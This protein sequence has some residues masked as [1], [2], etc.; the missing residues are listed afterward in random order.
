MQV[1]TG[2][3]VY[4]PGAMQKALEQL[5]D[6]KIDGNDLGLTQYKIPGTV[7][8][9]SPYGRA[10]LPNTFYYMLQGIRRVD[11]PESIGI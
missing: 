7:T 4:A 1:A 3:S 9:E 6:W 5:R 10:Y 8:E 11:S 2:E